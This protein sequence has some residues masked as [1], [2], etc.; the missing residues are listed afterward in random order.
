MILKTAASGYD[1]KGQILV[2]TAAEVSVAWAAWWPA[3]LRRGRG[4]VEFAAEVSVV[5]ARSGWMAGA[6]CYP[7]ALN[8]H[9]RHVLDSDHAASASGADW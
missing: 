4:W 8:R 6:M 2:E 5:V 9:E 1:G 3:A 7:V